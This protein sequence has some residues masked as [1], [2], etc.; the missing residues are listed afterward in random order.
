MD[1]FIGT[2]GLLPDQ[3]WN[4]TLADLIRIKEAW[5]HN[6]GQDWDR[7]RYQTTM[8]LNTAFG[9]KKQHKPTDLLK[10]PH[11][12]VNFARRAWTKDEIKQIERDF[13]DDIV[14]LK[15]SPDDIN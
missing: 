9:Q 1:L 12:N 6:Q 2:I 4:L 3:F 8:I 11:D 15:L 13:E 5:T 14:N 7:T 10:L